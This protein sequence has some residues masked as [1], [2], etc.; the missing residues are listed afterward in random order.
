VH[1]QAVNKQILGQGLEEGA[2]EARDHNAVCKQYLEDRV[3]GALMVASSGHGLGI[4]K[5]WSPWSAG[6]T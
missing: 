6:C 4:S 2:G 5:R 1:G 3:L